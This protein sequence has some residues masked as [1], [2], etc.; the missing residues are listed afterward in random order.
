MM[1]NWN[2]IKLLDL[3]EET[4]FTQVKSKFKKILK[5]DNPKIKLILI[6]NN[7]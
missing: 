7:K 1:K 3:K 6:Q 5:I 4:K 2:L